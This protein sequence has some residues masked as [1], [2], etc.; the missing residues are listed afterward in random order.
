MFAMLT[1]LSDV[2]YCKTSTS[3]DDPCVRLFSTNFLP[4]YWVQVLVSLETLVCLPVLL[5]YFGKFHLIVICP[6]EINFL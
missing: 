5:I 4:V 2:N 3:T 6:V 1:V